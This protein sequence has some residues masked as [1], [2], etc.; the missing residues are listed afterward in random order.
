MQKSNQNKIYKNKIPKCPD[1][2]RLN[3]ASRAPYKGLLLQSSGKKKKGKKE[4]NI[5]ER[6]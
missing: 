1:I 4:Q 3:W 2:Q 6:I 5:T